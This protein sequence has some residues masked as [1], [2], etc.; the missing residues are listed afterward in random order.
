MVQAATLLTISGLTIA[1][2][3][4]G[5]DEHTGIFMSGIAIGVIPVLLCMQY[6]LRIEAR[7]VEHAKHMERIIK[8]LAREAVRRARVEEL[9]RVS[10][11][12][13]RLVSDAMP[14]ML[15][16]IDTEWRLRFHN[17]AYREWLGIDDNRKVDGLTV[18]DLLGPQ[19]FAQ[20]RDKME[21]ALAGR[22]VSY[23]RTQV[24]PNGAVYHLSV[25]Y[26]P[27]FGPDGKVIGFFSVIS[28]ITERRHLADLPRPADFALQG[29]K[30]DLL[31]ISDGSDH[32]HTPDAI[33]EQLTGWSRPEQR[34]RQALKHNEFQIYFQPVIPLVLSMPSQSCFKVLLRLQEEED[35]H[36]PPGTFIPVAEQF[37]LTGQIDRWMIRRVADWHA[38][39]PDREAAK[40]NAMY[41][42]SLFGATFADPQFPEYVAAQLKAH[43]MPAGALCFELMAEEIAGR[44]PE[45]ATFAAAMRRI[46]CGLMLTCFAGDS[47][48]LELLKTLPV[49]YLRIDG[50]MAREVTRDPA[51]AWLKGLCRVSR[52]IGVRVI[53]GQV[54][55][56]SLRATL[57]AAGVD[58]VQGYG[59]MRA[60][61]HDAPVHH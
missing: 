18:T 60:L 52:A 58:Y 46:G 6:I 40:K 29:G 12:K 32:E 9:L 36:M 43:G 25:L 19:A 53:T 45:A 13:L 51:L 38:K 56:G 1:A 33:T 27:H 28:D 5:V 48:M 44:M 3:Y 35:N 39:S 55:S 30:G 8:P 14:S 42:V 37:N 16:Y 23:E 34:L 21:K 17:R 49:Q 31:V 47:A 11:S 50:D 4:T 22:R 26:L 59:I 41:S 10:E 20:I 57:R 24:M 54:E 15:I 2:H 7:R 61:P